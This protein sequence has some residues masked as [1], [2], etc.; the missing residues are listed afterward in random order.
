MG[1][2]QN[3][4]KKQNIAFNEK[5]DKEISNS[6]ACKGNREYLCKFKET[7]K[8]KIKKQIYPSSKVSEIFANDNLIFTTTHKILQQ[9]FDSTVNDEY[10][11]NH[12]NNSFYNS[13]FFYDIIEESSK[14]EEKFR[15]E[16]VEILTRIF[17]QD[18]EQDKILLTDED[19]DLGFSKSLEINS[20]KMSKSSETITEER[21]LKEEVLTKS[22][23]KSESIS[24]KNSVSKSTPIEQNKIK[25]KSIKTFKEKIE[26]ATPP[27]NHLGEN[28]INNT[29]TNKSYTKNFCIDR[30][31]S[32]TKKNFYTKAPIVN[33]KIDI[34]DFIRQDALE[35]SFL[36]ERNYHKVKTEK[37][38]SK[39]VNISKDQTISNV[40]ETSFVDIVDVLNQ[41]KREYIEAKKKRTQSKSPSKQDFTAQNNFTYTQE[42]SF[43]DERKSRIKYKNERYAEHSP[44]H[45]RDNILGNLKSAQKIK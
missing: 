24:E 15:K 7:F 21:T 38:P 41:T 45:N 39:R 19:S 1:N 23:N 5:L 31:K 11:R 25:S 16:K 30:P 22:Q 8:Q 13:I 34:K 12:L 9:I 44:L 18:C 4:R 27:Q 26:N 40:S 35:K 3:F 17:S 33:I 10:Y 28:L 42:K 20:L 43:Q 2:K 37:S 14:D 36:T 32:K 29:S 6:L